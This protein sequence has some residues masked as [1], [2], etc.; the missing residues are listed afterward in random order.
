MM[1]GE[2]N[3]ERI[4]TV[5]RNKIT[6]ANFLDLVTERPNKR[7]KINSF[8]CPFCKSKD[9]EL[10]NSCTTLVAGR[11]ED[12]V[13]HVWNYCECNKCHEKFTHEH[14]YNN[15]WYTQNR[16]ILLGI[17]SCFESYIYTCKHCGGDVESEDYDIKTGEVATVLVSTG[18][19]TK[20]YKTVFQC[21]KC[22]KQTNSA[23]EY[24]SDNWK[25]AVKTKSAKRE[26]F[27]IKRQP[28]KLKWCIFET[29]GDC[30]SN[31][32]GISK[33]RISED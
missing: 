18:D 12:D 30:Y 3:W 33:L 31:I 32:D 19:G 15:T 21:K 5:K 27:K 22:H 20:L 13:N 23:I 11:K 14:H 1:N 2:K 25:N 9:V 28:R 8:F 17:P 16:K 4:Q 7:L 6:Q 10:V 29:I 26:K 24:W